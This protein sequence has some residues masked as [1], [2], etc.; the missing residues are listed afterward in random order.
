MQLP[1]CTR[2]HARNVEGKEKEESKRKKG[3]K[4]LKEERETNE[5]SEEGRKKG[6]EI[7]KVQISKKIKSVRHLMSD[8][9]STQQRKAIKRG[10]KTTKEERKR[11]FQVNEAEK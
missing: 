4:R 2:T 8:L 11:C 10:E 7:Q 9:G 6:R 3:G 1:V 5:D